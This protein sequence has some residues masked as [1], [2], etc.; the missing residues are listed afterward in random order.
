MVETGRF[1]FVQDDSGHWY[2]IPADITSLSY[3]ESWCL[4]CEDD[5][6]EDDYKGPDYEECRLDGGPE[7]YS[8]TDPQED[9]T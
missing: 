3:F 6:E 9:R 4:S 7:S 5:T 2:S 8:F 1:R